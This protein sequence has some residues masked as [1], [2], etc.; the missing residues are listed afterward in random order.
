QVGMGLVMLPQQA[1]AAIATPGL[2][3]G[4]AV[5]RVVSSIDG[6]AQS[7][8]YYLRAVMAAPSVMNLGNLNVTWQQRDQSGAGLV[9]VKLGALNTT[10][11]INCPGS[12]V[13][14]QLDAQVG[15]YSAKFSRLGGASDTIATRVEYTCGPVVGGVR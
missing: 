3:P 4:A 15:D 2:A 7:Q 14:L 1:V 5:A 13:L 6:G 10:A 11:P 9:G 8:G 12:G